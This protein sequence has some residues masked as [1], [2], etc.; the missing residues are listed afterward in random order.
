MGRGEF[1]LA[2]EHLITATETPPNGWNPIGDHEV[3]ILLADIGALQRDKEL[4]S[5]YALRSSR[6][7]LSLNHHLY[8]AIALRALAILDWLHHDLA[9]AE[10]RLKESC[11]LFQRLETHWQLGRT[12]FDLGE[13]SAIMGKQDEAEIYIDKAQS[14]FKTMGIPSA[15]EI[16]DRSA[17]FPAT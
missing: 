6:I 7:S 11:Q 15:Q 16:P 14:A 13:L 3:Y 9:R 17:H 8:H 1:A 10:V 5:A 4:L 12:L 2:K